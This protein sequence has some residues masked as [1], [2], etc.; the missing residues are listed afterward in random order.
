MEVAIFFTV[1]FLSSLIIKL[2]LNGFKLNIS[3]LL[4]TVLGGVVA[5][6]TLVTITVTQQPN[7]TYLHE[8]NISP[9]QAHSFVQGLYDKINDD[10]KLIEDAFQDGNSQVL[11][12]YILNDWVAYAQQPHQY[13]PIAVADFGNKYFPTG[14][15]IEP[16]IACDTTF[17]NLF[18]YASAMGKVLQND[19]P[20]TRNILKQEADDYFKA[21]V[22]CQQQIYMS[23]EH[24]VI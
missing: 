14:D 15:A 17:I 12:T 3:W 23:D 13:A 9:E 1:F 22:Q 2:I 19:S 4:P 8:D 24:E 11:S 21:K 20:T 10:E 5:F 18:I 7:T 6:I 16:Y